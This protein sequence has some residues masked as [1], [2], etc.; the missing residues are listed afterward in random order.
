MVVVT[1]GAV[2]YSRLSQPIRVEN[3]RVAR[4]QSNS[5]GNEFR[6][7]GDSDGVATDCVR[8]P[9]PAVGAKHYRRKVPTACEL[10]VESA[11]EWSKNSENDCGESIYGIAKLLAQDSMQV[12]Q[13]RHRVGVENRG[14]PQCVAG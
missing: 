4:P 3:Q 8:V 12:L 6:L 10:D 1:L 7:H 11:V 5:G 2:A 14:R 13:H 9:R